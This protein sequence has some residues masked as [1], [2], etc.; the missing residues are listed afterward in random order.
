MAVQLQSY[1]LLKTELYMLWPYDFVA[2]G[3]VGLLVIENRTNKHAEVDNKNNN[4]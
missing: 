3:G 1:I 2:S 4:V